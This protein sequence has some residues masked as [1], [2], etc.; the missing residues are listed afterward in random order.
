MNGSAKPN[1]QELVTPLSP[2]SLSSDSMRPR[3]RKKCNGS[4]RGRAKSPNQTA[5]PPANT[6]SDEEEPVLVSNG[7]AETSPRSRPRS[8]WT[9]DESSDS[10]GHT[11]NTESSR[12]TSTSIEEEAAIQ[13][14][15]TPE[16]S[17]V[18]AK[19]EPPLL[20]S[21]VIGPGGFG[22]DL[23]SRTWSHAH[24]EILNLIYSKLHSIQQSWEWL[25]SA[26]QRRQ[27]CGESNRN[28][29]WSSRLSIH[30]CIWYTIHRSCHLH[31]FFFFLNLYHCISKIQA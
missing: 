12:L 7:G 29:R 3:S 30:L 10:E 11:G 19:E 13:Y 8:P 28:E 14:P 16:S 18:C 31:L 17:L 2:R 5:T 4:S 6:D 24:V 20:D 21:N 26:S 1:G 22:A 23:V 9:T 15:I 25:Y 27:S